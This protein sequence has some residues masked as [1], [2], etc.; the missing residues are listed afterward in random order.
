MLNLLSIPVAIN[1]GG[2]SIALLDA[3]CAAVLTVSLIVGA[4]KGFIKQIL[5]ILGWL[6]AVIIAYMLADK[7]A[8][9]ISTSMPAIPDAIGSKINEIL[10]FDSGT[11]SGTKDDIIQILSTSNI[12]AFMHDIIAETIIKSVGELNLTGLL[13]EWV[14]VAVSFVIIVLICLI[15]FAVVKKV[16]N[17]LTKIAIIGAID[18]VLGAMFSALKALVVII[19]LTI[20]ISLLFNI[21]AFLSPVVDGV[22]I[23][24]YLNELLSFITN[25]DFIKNLITL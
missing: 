22:E 21:N 17:A 14:L 5:S 19:L 2:A 3:I 11:L 20:L 7:V 8:A 18:R 4:I 9:F 23:K 12:P 16:F 25:M 15:L 24:C 1:L 13:A 6:L 10:H